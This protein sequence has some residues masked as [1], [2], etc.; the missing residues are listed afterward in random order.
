MTRM[1]GEHM[2]NIKNRSSK[3]LIPL[4]KVKRAVR[5]MS[6]EALRHYSTPEALRELHRRDKRRDKKDGIDG[7]SK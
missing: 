2:P 5:S 4:T 7:K 1:P 3:N 6:T